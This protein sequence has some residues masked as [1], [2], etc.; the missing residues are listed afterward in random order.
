MKTKLLTLALAALTIGLLGSCKKDNGPKTPKLPEGALSGI[1]SVSADKKVYFSKGNLVATIDNSGA[2]TAWKFAANQYDYIGNAIANNSIGS[3]AGDIDL[4]GWS[5]STNGGTSTTD[6][7]GIKTSTTGSD[8]SGGFYDWGKAVG[9]GNTWRTLSND[10]WTYLFT[11]HSKKWATVNGVTG[12]VI[13]PDGFAGTLSDTYADDAE[14]ATAGNLVFL[15]AAGYRDGS[16]VSDVGVCGLYWSST[17]YDIGDAHSVGFDS[18]G[19]SPDGGYRNFGFS[20]RLIA[21]CQ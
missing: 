5:T 14:L 17:A 8:Y 6:N 7:Y 19:V 15:P 12:Y 13:A 21:E 18:S 4:F 9:D 10:E 11:N 16:S 20:V 1:F 3:T 2:P